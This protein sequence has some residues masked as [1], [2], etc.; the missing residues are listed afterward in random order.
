[1]KMEKRTKLEEKDEKKGNVV[2]R[3]VLGLSLG[4]V[5]VSVSLFLNTNLT[6]SFASFFVISGLFFLGI[7]FRNRLK[8]AEKIKKME[9]AFPDFLQLMASN[10]RVSG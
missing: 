4:L 9:D 6:I 8:E 1:M 7:Y 5:A 10:L 3:V 2:L